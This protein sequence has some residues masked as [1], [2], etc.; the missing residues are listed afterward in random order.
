MNNSTPS[1]PLIVWLIC[2]AT[3]I[4]AMAVIGAITRLTESGLSITEWNPITG[5][6]PP[7]S[8]A[9]WQDEYAKWQATPQAKLV[10]NGLD[11]AGFKSIFFWE[12]IHRLWGRLIGLVYALPLLWF[13]IKNKIPAGYHARL[14][15]LLVLGGLQ[16]AVGWFMVQ[17]GLESRPTVSHYRLALHLLFALT[18]YSALVW[19]ILD[20]RR[21]QQNKPAVGPFACSFCLRRHGWVSLLFLALTIC[22]GAF[23]AGLDA[24]LVYNTFPLMNG[25]VL[26]PEALTIQPAWL[27]LFENTAMVQ[28]IHRM[29]AM[30]TGILILSWSLRLL[31][32]KPDDAHFQDYRRLALALGHTVLLQ[33]GL[34]IATLLLMVP[35]WLGALHQANAIVLLTFMIMALHR[36][37]QRQI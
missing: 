17:S 22:W 29:L 8:D 11:L 31:A 21:L 4:F 7:L 34:G 26:P 35:I 14:L 9:D 16:G 27:N 20:L 5:A 36:V 15:L 25:H 12:W 28:F 19:T 6:I 23:V 13:W 1:Q 32:I 2:C 37:M 30:T 33:I 10:L 24:G 3:M 18:L